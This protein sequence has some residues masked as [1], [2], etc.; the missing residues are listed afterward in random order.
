MSCCITLGWGWPRTAVKP[1][2]A[3]ATLCLPGPAP[4]MACRGGG[5]FDSGQLWRLVQRVES[6]AD[7]TLSLRRRL[8]EAARPTRSQNMVTE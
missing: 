8:V 4:A 3:S 7:L 6:E 5:S 1:K 2:R